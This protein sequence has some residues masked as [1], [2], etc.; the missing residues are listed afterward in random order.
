MPGQLSGRTAVALA[1]KL[2]ADTVD[3]GAQVGSNATPKSPHARLCRSQYVLR[4]FQTQI[5]R[6]EV[7]LAEAKARETEELEKDVQQLAEMT[8]DLAT[9]T[10]VHTAHCWLVA[11]F[12]SF[13][14][15]TTAAQPAPPSFHYSGGR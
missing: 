5:L 9:L 1:E 15:C 4:P 11:L 3:V 7:E 13:V 14:L 6:E 10:Q 8:T 12:L 2:D